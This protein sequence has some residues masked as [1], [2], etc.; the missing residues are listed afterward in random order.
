MQSRIVQCRAEVVKEHGVL[1]R[2]RY[3]DRIGQDRIG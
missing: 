3:E 1:E 2:E